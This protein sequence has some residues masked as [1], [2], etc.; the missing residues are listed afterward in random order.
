LSISGT[1]FRRKLFAGEDI[2]EWF[3][4]PESIKELQ[5]GV[6]KQKR[7]GVTIFF[8]GLSGSG[9]S[10]V[11]NI[12]SSRLLELQDREV[13]LLDGDVI[14]NH[15][16][17]ELGFSKEHRDLNVQRVGYVASEITKHGGIAICAL[18]APYAQARDKARELVESQGSFVEVHV[19]TPLE[20]CEQRDVKGLYEKARNGII[21][22]FTGI[23]DPYEK[24][25]SPEYVIDTSSTSPEK[26]AQDI[27]SFLSNK[28]YIKIR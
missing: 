10:T 25:E 28:N 26:L 15:L 12:L 23:D 11:A 18:I 1:E 14:R 20:V 27:L 6:A 16:T 2:P 21:K 13:T 22:G 4:F 5:V 24:P 9:K 7:R 19:S 8:T 3:S 17:S